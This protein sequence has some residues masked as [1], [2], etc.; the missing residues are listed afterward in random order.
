[1]LNEFL[2]NARW[3][4]KFEV[5]A[6]ERDRTEESE[7]RKICFSEENM[8]TLAKEMYS[9]DD[10]SWMR[11][12]EERLDELLNGLVWFMGEFS[13]YSWI[14][15]CNN[16]CTFSVNNQ[17]LPTMLPLLYQWFEG[18]VACCWRLTRKPERKS[19]YSRKV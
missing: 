2:I 16:L 4:N 6:Y 17:R 14:K 1:M 11:I 7:L 19:Q 5:A 3:W 9:I 15:G 13:K 18:A 12:L 10:F 8:T